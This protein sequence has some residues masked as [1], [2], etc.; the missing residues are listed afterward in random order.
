MC[1]DKQGEKFLD[2]TY[3]LVYTDAIPITP[4]RKG[5][6]MEPKRYYDD[7]LKQCVAK[8]PQTDI[9]GLLESIFN[10]MSALMGLYYKEC[11]HKDADIELKI[12]QEIA[13]IKTLVRHR[14]DQF[15]DE[16]SP[17]ALKAMKSKQM[18]SGFGVPCDDQFINDATIDLGLIL[19]EFGVKK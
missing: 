10:S 16:P 17:E 13:A 14:S 18:M 2:I 6:N 5:V 4:P 19:S 12:S 3:L 9:L 8:L 11:G 15:P 1:R 7:E